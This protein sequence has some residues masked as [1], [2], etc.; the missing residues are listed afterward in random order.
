MA[1]GLDVVSVGVADKGAVVRGVV[2]GP[3]LR[4]MQDFG[5]RFAGGLK[6]AVDRS[7][8]GC[9]ERNVR[10]PEPGTG[11]VRPEPEV[12]HRWDAVPDCRAGEFDDPFA[13]NRGE[14]HIVERRTSGWVGALDRQ[15]FEHQN[16]RA[17]ETTEIPAAMKTYE[18]YRLGMDTSERFRSLHAEGTFAMPNPWDVGSARILESMG[19]QAVA[20]TSSGQAAT[21]AKTDGHVGFDQLLAHAEELVAAIDIPLNLDSERCFADTPEGV[22]ANVLRMAETGAAGLSIEDYE[23]TTA[24]ID[25]LPAT[26]ERYQAAAEAANTTGMT[27]TG[28]CERHL[29]GATDVDETIKR[30]QA[31]ADAGVHVLYAP[32]L[33]DLEVIGQVVEHVD[34][35][36]NV[37]LNPRGPSIAELASVGV[38]RVSTGGALARAAYGA[39]MAGANELLD[40]GTSSYVNDAMPNATLQEFFGSSDL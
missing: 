20:T 27:L 30:L 9:G 29:Y 1:D 21:L 14:H 17:A 8:V 25:P 33:L 23:P 34:L 11:L 31:F 28:R 13:P 38:R 26:I 5:T 10:F 36:I 22:H 16:L 2:L 32:G 40:Q 35:P 3:H 4:L 24:R 18:S 37:L 15:V 6:E 12:R 39:L 7:S 19:F